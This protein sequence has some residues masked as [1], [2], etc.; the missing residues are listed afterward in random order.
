MSYSYL[1]Y[2]EYTYAKVE[3]LSILLEIK[4]NSRTSKAMVS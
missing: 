1:I 2:L 3:K 4:T